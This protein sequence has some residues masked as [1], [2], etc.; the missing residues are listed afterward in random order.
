MHRFFA[1]LL[2]VLLALGCFS[3][4]LGEARTAIPAATPTPRPTLAP[5]L[6]TPGPNEYTVKVTNIGATSYLN[7]RA[8]PNTKSA[9]L[10]QL[11]YGQPLL[12]LQE[13]GEWLQVKT[14]ELTG[15]VM[16]EFVARD[17]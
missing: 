2:A 16:A 10:S 12:V 11:Y 5:L 4:A 9:V 6:Q 8:E 15:Y 1:A 13:Q 17:Q 3:F 14:D 7:L